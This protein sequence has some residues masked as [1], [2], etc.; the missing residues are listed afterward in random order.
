MV[1]G[2]PSPAAPHDAVNWDQK[3]A[4]RPHVTS[5]SRAAHH[6]TLRLTASPRCWF[7]SETGRTHARAPLTHGAEL[8]PH[9]CLL[10]L[11]SSPAASSPLLATTASTGAWAEG[12]VRLA[13]PAPASL[14]Y[15]IMTERPPLTAPSGPLSTTYLRVREERIQRAGVA[16]LLLLLWLH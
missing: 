5:N 8:Q 1:Q 14:V 3:A 11:P 12:M 6:Q 4:K 2:T 16:G 7:G 15:Q 13:L 10:K 9:T